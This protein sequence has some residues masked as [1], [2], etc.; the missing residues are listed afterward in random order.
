MLSA[1][2]NFFFWI[3]DPWNLCHVSKIV[4][5]SIPKPRDY[6][7]TYFSQPYF[8]QNDTD[9]TVGKYAPAI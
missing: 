5:S 8:S 2:L 4:I 7:S 9:K 3:Y 1:T 6:F